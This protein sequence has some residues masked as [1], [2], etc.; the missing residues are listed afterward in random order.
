V[1]K[2]RYTGQAT[3]QVIYLGYD[4]DQGRLFEKDGWFADE[5]GESGY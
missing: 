2:D 3:G 5:G 1:L 4:A